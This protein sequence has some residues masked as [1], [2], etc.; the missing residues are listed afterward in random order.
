MANRWA[1]LVGV[2][3]CLRLEAG[4]MPFADGDAQAFAVALQVAGIPKSQQFASIGMMATK[5][6]I[7]SRLRSLNEKLK[8]GDEVV[9]F[10]FGV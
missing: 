6:Q 3:K 9:V 8:K 7:E 1:F 5:S 2:E 4:D 10:V